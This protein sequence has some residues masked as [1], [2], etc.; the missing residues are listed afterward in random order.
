M[1]QQQAQIRTIIGQIAQNCFKLCVIGKPGTRLSGG[2]QE[3]MVRKQASCPDKLLAAG[4]RSPALASPGRAHRRAARLH[5]HGGGGQA[6]CTMRFL[7]VTKFVQTKAAAQLQ[8][9]NDNAY[10]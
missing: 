10:E 6:N 2:E 9:Q 4:R 5:L 7:D 8:P 1:Q 3:C